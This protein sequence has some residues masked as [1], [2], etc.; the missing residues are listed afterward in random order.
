MPENH[1]MERKRR[2]KRQRQDRLRAARKA[3]EPVEAR[4][5]VERLGA[6]GDGLAEHAGKPAFLPG[7]LPGETVTADLMPA[8]GGAWRGT[9]RSLLT[10]SQDRIAPPCPHAA[11]CGGCSL[12]HWAE[13]PYLAWKHGLVVQ[14]LAQRGFADAEDLVEPLIAIT[15]RSRR[16]TTLQAVQGPRGLVLGFH[17]RRSHDLVQLEAC[18]LLT[19]A[20]IALLPG[21]KR[22]LADVLPARGS[23]SL[24]LLDSESGIDLLLS[25]SGEPDLAARETLAAFAEEE[26]LARLS[27]SFGNDPPLPLAER[28][29]PVVTMGGV[30]VSPQ[31]GGFLQPSAAGQAALTGAVLAAVPEGAKRVAD[32][33]AGCGTFSFPLAARGH[34]VLA[35]EGD[36]GALAA[37]EAARRREANRLKI[38]GQPRDLER[39]PL[40]GPELGGLD[41][42]VFDP[43]RSGAKAQAEALANDPVVPRLVAVSCNPATF[44]RDARILADAG[45]RLERV[46]P[47]DQFPWSGHLELVAQ[48]SR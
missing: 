47:I 17:G 13:A 44:A 26:D 18:L 27:L 39:Q 36:A 42:L 31:A 4:L 37:L 33:F 45:Y 14:A 22:L 43:P 24:A 10:A 25:L 2:A 28:R 20:L 32:L 16:R 48:L 23:A 3:F 8:G 12:Q 6:Q 40:A 7:T 29:R 9:L 34:S 35:V 11:D 41:A 30:P 21:L 19:P 15:P 5:T 46:T 1:G 38:A